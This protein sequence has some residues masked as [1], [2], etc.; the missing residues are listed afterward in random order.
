MTDT[1]AQHPLRIRWVC[2]AWLTWEQART[3]SSLPAHMLRDLIAERR[4]RTRAT[5][6]GR[7]ISR[8][9]IDRFLQKLS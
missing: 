9:S 2:P 5:S 8:D 3:Y 6:K 4:L 1:R 7:L